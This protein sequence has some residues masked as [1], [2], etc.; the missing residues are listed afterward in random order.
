MTA[1]SPAPALPT[2]F[3]ADPGWFPFLLDRADVLTLARIDEPAL[4]AASFLDERGVPPA[5]ER[6]PV[7][8]AAA[9]A[10]LAPGARRD[11]QYIFHIGH[12]GSTLVSR[13]LGELPS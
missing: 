13:L 10:A 9:A 6:R 1:A 4:R 7:P 12:V 8:W 5:A 2:G 11:L 3:A